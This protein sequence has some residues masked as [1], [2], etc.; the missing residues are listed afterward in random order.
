[1]TSPHFTK[2]HREPLEGFEHWNNGHTLVFIGP[3]W[4]LGENRPLDHLGGQCNSL[5]A[6][7]ARER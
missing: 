3:L 4:L 7:A 2:R 1:M 5:A 6:V